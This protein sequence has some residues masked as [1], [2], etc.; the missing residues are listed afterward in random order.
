MSEKLNTDRICVEVGIEKPLVVVVVV[1]VEVVRVI[2][3]IM[4]IVL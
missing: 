3:L 4:A 2:L 1:V